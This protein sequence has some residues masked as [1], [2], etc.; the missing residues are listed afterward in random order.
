MSSADMFLIMFVSYCYVQI[1]LKF[2][3][4]HVHG[5]KCCSVDLDF[6]NHSSVV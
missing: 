2:K 1:L 4:K 3:E 5:I 6:C